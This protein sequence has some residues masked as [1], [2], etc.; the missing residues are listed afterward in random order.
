MRLVRLDGRP[1]G[2]SIKVPRQVPFSA[3]RPDGAGYLLVTSLGGTYATR[4]GIRR[5][6]TQGQL[7]AIGRTGWLARECSNAACRLVL[8]QRGDGA[9]EVLNIP[10]PQVFGV[11]LIAPDGN[12]VALHSQSRS[13]APV[14]VSVGLLTGRTTRV[15]AVP[16]AEQ[17]EDPGAWSPDGR[18]LFVSEAGGGV[19][20]L[21]TER[22]TTLQLGRFTPP[23]VDTAIRLAG[24]TPVQSGQDPQCEVMAVDDWFSTGSPTRS[25]FCRSS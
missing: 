16:T 14:V 15:A 24:Q 2:T 11:G 7:L 5:L 1:T 20:V 23:L 3:V 13:G 9:R 17:G 18:Y 12:D 22:G 25:A 19:A 10:V 6:V 21:D 4:P 8:V